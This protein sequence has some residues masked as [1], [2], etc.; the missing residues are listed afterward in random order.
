MSKYIIIDN[1]AA[2]SEIKLHSYYYCR[3][4]DNPQLKN[5]ELVIIYN[6]HFSNGVTGDFYQIPQTFVR[7]EADTIEELCDGFV[8]VYNN[9][10]NHDIYYPYVIDIKDMNLT[11]NNNWY[12]AIW[13]DKGLIYVAKLNEKGELEFKD[14]GKLGH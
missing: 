10:N 9:D 13:T 7:K 5:I 8:C 11:K 6:C 2:L 14:Y 12:V 4:I 3:V 1:I